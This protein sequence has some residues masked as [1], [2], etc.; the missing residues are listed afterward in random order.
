MN[1]PSSWP[2]YEFAAARRIHHFPHP[3]RLSEPTSTTTVSLSQPS[4]APDLTQD[5]PFPVQKD[6]PSTQEEYNLAT[7]KSLGPGLLR[8]PSCIIIG[9]PCLVVR[10]DSER[11]FQR[12]EH[13]ASSFEIHTHQL[14]GSTLFHDSLID[15]Y[16]RLRVWHRSLRSLLAR[17]V[18]AFST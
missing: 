18:A 2:L 3:L 17:G 1:R 15:R 4:T 16:W 12:Y 10:F 9:R 8:L 11:K 6:P 13:L 7:A 5:S 14:M